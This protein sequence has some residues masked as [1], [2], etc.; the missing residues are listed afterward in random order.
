MC[1]T[2]RRAVLAAILAAIAAAAI[3]ALTA[4]SDRKAPQKPERT[5]APLT[6]V[7]PG[8]PPI[9]A[10]TDNEQQPDEITEADQGTER[11]GIA[12]TPDVHEDARDETPPGVPAASVKRGLEQTTAPGKGPAQPVGGAQNYSCP[13]RLVR[14]RSSRRGQRPLLFVLHYTVSRPGSLDAIRGLFNTPSFG[15]SSH[16]GIE[17]TGRCQQWVPFAENAWTE[18]A[19]NGRAES[20]EIIA[21]G[22]E[23]RAQ[24]L[25]SPL[26]RRGILASL[27]RDRLRANGLPPRLV[28]PD[29]CGVQQAGFT[30]HNRLE[31]GNSHHDVS[32]N[33]P[34]DVFQRQLA[35]QGSAARAVTRAQR[36]T[37][38]RLRWWR[39]ADQP[40]GQAR[41]NAIRRRK[42][43]EQRRVRCTGTRGP[44]TRR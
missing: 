14:N 13:Q 39:R 33:F 30:D 10:D 38:R 1:I 34:M 8:A 11:G 6:P 23:T 36:A 12:N 4:G 26:I 40:G 29:G 27:V 28:D 31:C 5:F 43:L 2:R 25:A 16:L 37:C 44:V 41:T 9:I 24:W 22:S 35:A 18:G 19:F 7:A 21:T 15:A 20:V 42:I 32:P 3:I 17:F